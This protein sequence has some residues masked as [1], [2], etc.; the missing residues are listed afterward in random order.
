MET[1]EDEFFEISAVARLTGISTPN[2]V[3][4]I[5]RISSASPC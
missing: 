5:A 2:G 4:I 1:H 3:G